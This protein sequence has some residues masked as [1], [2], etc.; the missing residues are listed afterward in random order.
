MSTE[1]SGHGD[2]RHADRQAR[3]QARYTELSGSALPPVHDLLQ[4]WV[5]AP[6]QGTALDLACGRGQDA[7]YLARCGYVTEAWDSAEAAIAA[8]RPLAAGVALHAEVRDV[9]R[10]PP[11]EQSYDCIHVANFMARPI[12]SRLVAALRSGGLLVYAT[13]C[14]SYRG[15]GP[16]D[17]DFRA[18]PGELA[19]AFAALT[20]LHYQEDE[21]RVA[22]VWRRPQ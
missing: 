3:W 19:T 15:R 5:R 20:C 7:L 17:P 9:L 1:G 10:A 18:G 14:G 11:K 4:A 22:G 21:E 8:L 16:R 12:F 13:W 6:Q 2:P